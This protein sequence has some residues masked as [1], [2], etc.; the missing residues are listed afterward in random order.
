MAMLVYRRVL[1]PFVEYP[2]GILLSNLFIG[3]PDHRMTPY[4]Q[5]FRLLWVPWER[6]GMM[7]GDPEGIVRHMFQEEWA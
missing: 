2:M 7:V 5:V 1:D 6:L 3:P 4:E